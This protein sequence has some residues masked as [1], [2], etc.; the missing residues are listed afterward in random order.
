MRSRRDGLAII[1]LMHAKW[2]L[3]RELI[4]VPGVWRY[5]RIRTV[6]VNREHSWCLIARGLH[7]NGV[8]HSEERRSR[9]SGS[10]Q[11]QF[12][13]TSSL[14]EI[15]AQGPAILPLIFSTLISLFG[16][17]ASLWSRFKSLKRGWFAGIAKVCIM[18]IN[19]INVERFP[20]ISRGWWDN[21]ARQIYLAGCIRRRL[22]AAEDA[23]Q[24]SHREEPRLGGSRE[25]RRGAHTR[26]K[27][28]QT[29]S[30]RQ[31]R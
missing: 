24:R 5:P 2:M 19:R 21:L 6:Q 27:R 9:V 26:P 11:S 15:S 7:R 14:N 28:I 20:A 8:T 18:G 25:A 22:S 16:E 17:R 12:H 4:R 31:A 23:R 10:P 13:W 1:F 29:K 30:Y 3:S